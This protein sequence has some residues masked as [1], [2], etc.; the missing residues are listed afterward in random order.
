MKKRLVIGYNSSLEVLRVRPRDVISLSYDA[1]TLDPSVQSFVDKYKIKTKKVSKT[2]LD[3]LGSGH[4]GLVLEVSTHPEFNFQSL[5]KSNLLLFLDELE[6]PQNLGA[7]LRTSWLMQVNG[8]FIPTQG[9]ANLSSPIVNKVASGGAEHV[10]V[11][12]VHFPSTVE[13]IKEAGFW[14]YGLSEQSSKSIYDIKFPPKTAFFMGNEGKGLRKTTQNLCDELC[15]IPQAKTGSSYNVS[16]ATAL[17]L[18]EYQRQH[19][20]SP[21]V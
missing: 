4:Q 15:F 3:K 6:D 11:E 21:K 10:P 8:V 12:E 14:C 13:Q 18:A 17:V 1:K 9:S 5:D 19:Q 2:E 7:I 16:V 20:W